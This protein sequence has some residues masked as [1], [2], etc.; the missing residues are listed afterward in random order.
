VIYQV[1]AEHKLEAAGLIVTL[2][3]DD[4]IAPEGETFPP[5]FEGRRVVLNAAQMEAA[6][7]I[8]VEY[9][10][11]EPKPGPELEPKPQPEPDKKRGGRK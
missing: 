8:L 2:K 6:K 7:D 3:P 9:K 1:K 5:E 4:L 11:L 10:P